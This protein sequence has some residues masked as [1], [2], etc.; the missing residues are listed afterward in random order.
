MNL[1]KINFDK[2]IAKEMPIFYYFNLL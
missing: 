1:K 2:E